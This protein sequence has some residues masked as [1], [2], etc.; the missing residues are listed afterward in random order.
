MLKSA[1][2]DTAR[3]LR[4]ADRRRVR[5]RMTVVGARVV[6]ELRGL[7]C[8]PV[9]RCPQPKKS[10]TCSRSFG[11]PVMSLTE[12]REAVAAYLTLAAER[13]R[14]HGMA[15]GAVTVWI[16]TNSFS[17]DPQ[18]SNTV[19]IELASQ[20]DATD[21]LM[22]WALQGL[23]KIYRPGFRYKKAGVML[24]RL[25]PA[26]RMTMRLYG[27]EKFERSRRVMKAL[28]E[29]SRKHGRGA[30]RFGIVPPATRWATR[31]T[32]RSQNFTTRLAEVPRVA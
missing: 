17:D 8:L 20:T 3:K 23:E 6:E 32:R 11:V 16:Y 5:R 18:Y 14:R 22:A 30:V 29:I 9:E 1:G 21:E 27:D 28:D 12:M 7:S 25:A 19:T 10:V 15:A 13:M 2:I 26:R 4:D 24:T 31:F